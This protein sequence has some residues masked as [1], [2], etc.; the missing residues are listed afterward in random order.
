MSEYLAAGA[1]GF[2]I[3]GNIID[4]NMIEN[5]DF[6]GITELAKRYVAA[7]RGEI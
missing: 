3:G 5:N 7:A 6:G 1:S 4:K 2:G